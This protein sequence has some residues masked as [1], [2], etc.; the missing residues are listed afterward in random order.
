ML[1]DACIAATQIYTYR[2]FQHLAKVFDAAHP[3]AKKA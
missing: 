3:R 2:D 1:G